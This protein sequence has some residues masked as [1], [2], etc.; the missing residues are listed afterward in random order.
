[1][2][3]H[4]SQAMWRSSA[5]PVIQSTTR[6]RPLRQ[7]ATLLSLQSQ[8]SAATKASAR[9]GIPNK[10]EKKSFLN[11]GLSILV[12]APHHPARHFP[13]VR[14]DTSQTTDSG[15]YYFFVI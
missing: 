14:L 15:N 10:D 11:N 8:N 5:A 7:G 2:K 13:T 6:Y 9:A 4:Y 3:T 1:M 12:I